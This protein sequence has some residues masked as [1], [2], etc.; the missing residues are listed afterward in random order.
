V[1]ELHSCNIVQQNESTESLTYVPPS[2]TLS[3]HYVPA[4]SHRIYEGN[5]QGADGT[6]KLEL[7]G[8]AIGN[9]LTNPEQQYPWYPE[10][11]WNNS[12]HIQVVSED[13]YETMKDVVPH[14]TSLIAKCN[15]GDGM[16][17]TFACQSAFV[18]CNM[19]LT[20]VH[21]MMMEGFRSGP[22]IHI[23]CLRRLTPAL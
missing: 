16:I 17:N 6:S 1:S 11:V 21:L 22:N 13:V 19:G 12:H 10:M 23:C 2:L 15:S 18:L 4:I 9:G 20:Y 5:Q 7:A 8:F 3:G 14:C